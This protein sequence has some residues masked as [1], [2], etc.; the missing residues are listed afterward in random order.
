MRKSGL[1]FAALVAFFIASWPGSADTPPPVYHFIP[2]IVKSASDITCRAVSGSVSG[3]L[4]AADYTKFNSNII[5]NFVAPLQNSSGLATCDV[6]SSSQP[7]C[8]SSTDWSTFNSKQTA[9]TLGNLTTS[10]SG[11][12]VGTGTGAVVGTGTTVN[13]QTASGSQPGLISAADWTTFN[14][15]QSTLTLGNLTSGTTGLTVTSGTGAVVGSGTSLTIQ[16]ASGSQPGLLSAADWT[17]FNNK[18]STLSF[19]APLVNTSG[20]VTC[21][22]ASGSQPGCLSSADWTT[23]NNKQG[24]ITTGNL[25]TSTTGVSIGSGTGAVIGS[26]STVNVQTAS[27]S[28]PGLISA[29][30][31]TTFNDTT[32]TVNAAT[33]AANPSTLVKRGASAEIAAGFIHAVNG[34]TIDYGGNENIGTESGSG[35]IFF[36]FNTSTKTAQFG[37]NGGAGRIFNAFSDGSVGE[38]LYNN[39]TNLGW[40]VGAAPATWAGNA[41]YVDVGNSKAYTASGIKFG[42]ANSSPSATLDVTGT[43]AFS[44]TVTASGFLGNAT[45]ATT[46]TSLASNPTDCGANTYANAID[47]QANLTCASITN[48]STTATSA[49][50]ASA[51]VARDSSGN[52]SAGTISAALTGNASTATAL[53]ANPTDCSSNQFANAI[54]A[55]GNLTCSQVG[56][57]ALSSSYLY[58]DGS[59]ALSSSW[60]AGQVITATNL[61]S[62]GVKSPTTG[63]LFVG[64]TIPGSLTGTYN[65][66][67][68]TNNSGLTSGG[69]N[70]L[71]GQGAGASLTT[72]TQNVI[73]GVN[74][75]NN[76]VATNTQIGYG[77]TSSGN[78]NVLVGNS[79]MIGTGIAGVSIGN[80]SGSASM[81]GSSN[82]SVGYLA[83]NTITSGGADIILGRE[84]GDSL[85]VTTSN[86]FSAGSASYPIN[87]VY[88]GKGYSNSSATAYTIHGTA[89]SG[90]NN[91]GANLVMAGG[92]GTGTGAGGSFIVQ[93]APAGSTGS[94]LNALATAL[95]IDSTGAASF[96][97][98]VTSNSVIVGSAANRISGLSSIV[99]GSGTLAVNSSGTVTVPNATD[100][101]VG[102]AT[103]DTLTNK[104]LTGNTAVNLVSGSGTL[105][106]NTSGTVTVPNATDTLVGKA[107]TDT[108]TNKSIDAAQLTG[109]VSVNRFNSGTGASS[110]TF[111]RGDG[112][113][114][115]PTASVDSYSVW[116]SSTG[117]SSL[118]TSDTTIPYATEIRDTGNNWAS[119]VFTAPVT[120]YFQACAGFQTDSQTWAAGDI[121]RLVI[122]VNATARAS[123]DTDL[124][125]ITQSAAVHICSGV[126]LTATD[127]ITFKARRITSVAAPSFNG[128]ASQNWASVVF[129]GS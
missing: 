88:F 8:L 48:A 101:L 18:Q 71:I 128:T 45:S 87:N 95:T 110:S 83:G 21:N 68:G 59:R 56:D 60:A 6:A 37:I 27:T 108:L 22:A 44:S 73:I 79:A 117:T 14:N 52:F 81:S 113:W 66:V 19:T 97:S 31:F 57:A 49:N 17:T 40:T 12:T 5:P 103:T 120:G 93:T 62:D 11:V 3:C 90:S 55:S 77:A 33:S 86:A 20:T 92:Q 28:Q 72:Q 26:G 107:T 67:L 61:T 124:A 2:P 74:A 38:F 50:T 41:F 98:T 4:S 35:Y 30:S 116:V 85:P 112:T 91:A 63:S 25:T 106:L 64:S 76:N 43:G 42:V 100:T 24:T 96:G 99:N 47:A 29:A 23:F 15:K 82:I 69:T 111:L 115:A 75:E 105:T 36:D 125:V 32:T 94:S 84:G 16:T 70:I 114:V 53:A 65:V 10:T 121:V 34:M 46:A 39:G 80:N 104:T 54:A 58:A 9:L 123:T 127:T 129:N 7:G 51:I 122:Y 13:I 1:G 118:G 102:K 126:Y 119:N 89:G 78:A 109:T